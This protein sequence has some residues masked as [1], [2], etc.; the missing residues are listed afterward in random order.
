MLMLDRELSIENTRTRALGARR[1]P[2]SVCKSTSR[3]NGSG[4]MF[5]FFYL[6]RKNT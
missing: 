6:T 4:E 3:M 5:R 1:L 2:R